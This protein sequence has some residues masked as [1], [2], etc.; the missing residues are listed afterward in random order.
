MA[1]VYPIGVPM[2]FLFMLVR[3]REKLNPLRH[4]DKSVAEK[5]IIRDK[6]HSIKHISFLFYAYRPGCW[7]YEAYEV[8]KQII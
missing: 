1:V 6:D 5:L 8:S 3:Y 7:W 2:T 4:Q